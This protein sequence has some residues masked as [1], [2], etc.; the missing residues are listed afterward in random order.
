MAILNSFINL[1][2]SGVCRKD[3]FTETLEEAEKKII[4]ILN[5]RGYRYDES[6]RI[7]LFRVSDEVRLAEAKEKLTRMET[8]PE[9]S[10]SEYVKSLNTIFDNFLDMYNFGWCRELEVNEYGTIHIQLCLTLHSKHFSDNPASAK[11]NFEN[12]IARLKSLGFE[13]GKDKMHD[14]AFLDTAKNHDLMKEFW[15]SRGARN[16]HI[17]TRGE[18]IYELEFHIQKVDFDN[19]NIDKETVCLYVS[20]ELNED[21]RLRIK[22]LVSEIESTISFNEPSMINTCGTLVESYFA[23]LCEIFGYDGEIRNIVDERHSKARK[24]NME[25]RNIEES[26]GEMFPAEKA[27]DVL[28]SMY[29]KLSRMA[30]NQIGFSCHNF[31]MDKYGYVNVELS[32]CSGYHFGVGQIMTDEETKKIFETI[33]D[34]RRDDS[35]FIVDSTENKKTLLRILRSSIPSLDIRNIIVNERNGEFYI[36]RMEVFIRNSLDLINL[37][38]GIKGEYDE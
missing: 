35:L 23:E 21:E 5:S 37:S 18:S 2:N 10:I 24:I 8:N 25:I 3:K 16:L 38:E 19:F 20:E 26:I 6:E 1:Y 34:S 11:I 31:K 32:Y 22:K 29:T 4:E 28:N 15:E 36:R 12:Q 7:N 30:V 27:R 13:I 14:N 9:T 17:T 33:G